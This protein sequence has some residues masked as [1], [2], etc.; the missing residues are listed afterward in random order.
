MEKKRRGPRKGESATS[1][2]RIQARKREEQALV[3]RLARMGYAEIATKLGYRSPSGAQQAVVRAMER[4]PMEPAADLREWE[5]R[6]LDELERAL[7]PRA[8]KG[9]APAVHAI[10]RCME[11]RAK[12]QGLDAPKR[13]KG[14]LTVSPSAKAKRLAVL[15]LLYPEGA[16]AGRDE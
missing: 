15:A 10:I 7:W 12:Y 6:R 11:R 13:I 14:E 9:Q 3:L 16:P 1:P 5:L 4:L 8:L 2:R